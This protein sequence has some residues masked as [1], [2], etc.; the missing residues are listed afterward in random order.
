MT[1]NWDRVKPLFQAALDMQPEGRTAFLAEACDDPDVRAAVQG[2]LAS[3]AGADDFLERPGGLNAAVSLALDAP[4]ITAGRRIGPYRTLR[5]IGEGGMGSVYLAAREDDEYRKE[6]AI[7]VIRCDAGSELNVRRFRQERQILADLDHANIARLIDG[8]TTAEGVPY[9]VM[10]LVDG[11]PI[12]IHCQ[13]TELSTHGRLELFRQVC[14]AVAHAHERGI[15]HRDLKPSNLLVTRDGNLKLLDFGIAKLVDRV[16]SN[17]ATATVARMLTPEYA[18]PEQIRGEPVTVASDIYSLGVLLYRLLTGRSPYRVTTDAPHELARA[19]CE[20]DPPRLSTTSWEDGAHCSERIPAWMRRNL[21]AI[22]FRA[23]R[24]S[25]THRY[26]SVRELDEDVR[27]CQGRLPLKARLSTLYVGSAVQRGRLMFAVLPVIILAAGI[28]SYLRMAETSSPASPV[29][30]SL[31]VLPFT[32]LVAGGGDEAIEVGMADALITRLSNLKQ[33]RVRPMSAVLRYA[34]GNQDVTAV[35]RELRVESLL[36]GK[37]QRA[38]DRLR[39][40]VQLVRARDRTPLWAETFDERFTDI[41]TVQDAISHKV[42]L[43][44]MLTLTREEAARMTR[45]Y[46][47]N[48]EAYQRY[49][50]GRYFLNKR[51]EEGYRKAIEYFQQGLEVDSHDALAHAGLADAYNLL[52]LFVTSAMPPREVFPRAKEAAV[53]ALQIDPDLAEAHSSLGYTKLVYDWDWPGA[54]T[55]FRRAI[56]LNPSYA[57]AHQ[58]YAHYF[59]SMGRVDEAIAQITRA[60]ELDP[61]SL[62][63]NRGFGRHL[64]FAR[65][66]D[67]AIEQERHTL[68]FDPNFALARYSLGLVYVQ[69]S[70]FNDAVAE[71]E[72]AVSL[73]DGSPVFLSAL[74]YGYARAGQRAEAEQVILRLKGLSRQRYVSAYNIALVH[75]GLGENE[76]ALEWLEKACD[77]RA[78]ALIFLKVAPEFDGLR[79]HPRFKALLRRIGLPP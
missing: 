79:A 64:Y 50:R 37:L 78:T 39:V 42:A 3:H 34:G 2:L 41:F 15:V 62:I 25:P 46:T 23:M 40:S 61:F 77:E 57:T 72:R 56:E 33:I 36:E 9:L 71:F 24:K 74:G 68:E 66:Y 12:D 18:S 73:T 29:A 45:R 13:R 47:D 4:G 65:E 1:P 32:P 69:K 51:T 54:Q 5:E 75:I 67:H 19:I 63:I 55:A 6:V 48:P 35:G 60:R 27:R 10:E 14:G 17:E 16:T 76:A 70:M 52:G 30:R 43:A 8:G 21:D 44:L 59:A 7:K 26:A 58:W 28:G 53:R 49:L 31:A 11:V 38:G 20:D 22:V